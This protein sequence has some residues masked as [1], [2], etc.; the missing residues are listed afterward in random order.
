[1]ILAT[2]VGDGE[3]GEERGGEEEGDNALVEYPVVLG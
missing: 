3:G 1:V 2:L